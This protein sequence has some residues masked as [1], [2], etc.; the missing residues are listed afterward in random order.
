MKGRITAIGTVWITSDLYIAVNKN[1]CG[2]RRI[3]RLYLMGRSII[4]RYSKKVEAYPEL[5]ERLL[6]IEVD[7]Y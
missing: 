4:E 7:L 5:S 6:L 2:N 3:G 1:N